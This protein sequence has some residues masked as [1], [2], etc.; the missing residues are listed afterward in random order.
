MTS[1]KI[2]GP[3]NIVRNLDSIP[4]NKRASV[5]KGI[6]RHK[7]ICDRC[8][9]PKHALDGVTLANSGINMDEVGNVGQ[10]IAWIADYR[11]YALAA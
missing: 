8:S 3:A 5:A 1:L 10:L 6:V 4:D 11:A 2:G 9:A 7:H